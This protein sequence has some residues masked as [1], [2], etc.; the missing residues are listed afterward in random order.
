MNATVDYGV[1]LQFEFRRERRSLLLALARFLAKAML[2]ITARQADGCGGIGKRKHF[3]D[4][5]TQQLGKSFPLVLL[6]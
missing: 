6:P 5:G 4:L 3:E 1:G 2:I